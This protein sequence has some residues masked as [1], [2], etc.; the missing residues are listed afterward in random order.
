MPARSLIVC[1]ALTVLCLCGGGALGQLSYY[2]GT[3]HYYELV[4]SSLLWD[5]ARN[6][7][8][9]LSHLGL[10]GHLASITSQTE[11]R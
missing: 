3:G 5:D 6:A 1:C 2:S 8:E 9:S 7:S 4:E 10:S 11:N